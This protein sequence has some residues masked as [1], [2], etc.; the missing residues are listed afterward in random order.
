MTID[1][2]HQNNVHHLSFIVQLGHQNNHELHPNAFIQDVFEQAL[3]LRIAV[4]ER[5]IRTRC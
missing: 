2:P 3:G 1:E 5:R 4:H